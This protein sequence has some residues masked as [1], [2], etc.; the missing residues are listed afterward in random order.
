MEKKIGLPELK[1][2]LL[3]WELSLAQ[4]LEARKSKACSETSN[5]SRE[6]GDEV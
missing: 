3:A 2:G 5:Q 1:K 6:A 4:S